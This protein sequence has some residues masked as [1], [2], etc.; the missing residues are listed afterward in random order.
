MQK[1]KNKVS[2]WGRYPQV[3]GMIFAPN[4]P[5]DLV[6]AWAD[7]PYFKLP[8]GQRRSYGDASLLASGVM[9]G[10]AHWNQILQLEDGL[11]T[12]QSGC[13]FDQILR[14]I[15][16][17]G[18][19]L[20]VTPGTKFVS[21]GG[22]IGSDVH[23]K[24]HVWRGSFSN[25][26]LSFKLLLADG[27]VLNC[28]R[29]QNT[30]VFWATLAGY[31]LTGIVL[32]ATF[33]LQKI[34]SPFLVQRT[35]KVPN[36]AETLRL[37]TQKSKEAPFTVAWIDGLAKGEHLGRSHLLCA[38][39][40]VETTPPHRW[41][42]H[43][44]RTFEIPSFVPPNILQK[45]TIKAF[46]V[47]Y[48]HKQHRLVKAQKIH[49]N[50][51]FYPLDALQH[52]HRLYGKS[53]FIQYQFVL[54]EAAAAEGLADILNRIGNAGFGA[55]LGVLKKMGAADAP[56]LAFPMQGYSLALDFKRERRLL[57]FLAELDQVV[58]DY[59]GRIYLTKDARLNAEDFHKM[60][61]NADKW[62]QI[63]A[64]IDPQNQFQSELSKRLLDYS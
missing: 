51:C 12:C 11:I 13:T 44:K 47:L 10:T 3:E 52:W 6:E 56:L 46:N 22:A 31:G 50:N 19:F 63:K 64:Q 18:W 26:V 57:A 60:Y 53:G 7:L 34:P 21:V 15:V 32:E 45:N 23:G 28:T 58:A 48:F 16:P 62:K 1:Y 40:E 49:Y 43:P 5:E 33:R 41:K 9:I 37:Y 42:I 59:G 30:E 24:D 39:W 20:P 2:G 54:P 25:F 36:L 61:P 35:Y 17:L 38:N 29:T 8:F 55:F 4:S 27:N 14:K